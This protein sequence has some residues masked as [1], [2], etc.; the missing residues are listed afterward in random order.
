MSLDGVPCK[1]LPTELAREPPLNVLNGGF[2]MEMGYDND[3]FD[4]SSSLSNAEESAMRVLREKIKQRVGIKNYG[5]G[6]GCTDLKRFKL[7]VYFTPLS[8]SFTPCSYRTTS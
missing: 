8:R 6:G 4:A 2:K 1:R 7:C 3:Q 5:N